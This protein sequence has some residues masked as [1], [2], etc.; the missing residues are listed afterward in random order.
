MREPGHSASVR[1]H[2]A[3]SPQ[4]CALVSEKDSSIGQG[5]ETGE[6][7]ANAFDN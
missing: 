2:F 6:V 1:A 7:A 5:A 3:I 4:A